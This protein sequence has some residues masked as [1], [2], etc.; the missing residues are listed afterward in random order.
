[1][2]IEF[3]DREIDVKDIMKQIKSNIAQ[4]GYQE[5][6]IDSAGHNTAELINIEEYQFILNRIWN[7][8]ADFPITTHRRGVGKL[9]VLGKKIIRKLT[10][11]YVNP[12]FEKQVDFNAHTV[13]MLNEIVKLLKSHET[14]TNKH[15]ENN[16]PELSATVEQLQNRIYE[17]SESVE[18]L[19]S[20]LRETNEFN[21]KQGQEVQSLANEFRLDA[22]QLRSDYNL[23]LDRMDSSIR[24]A[25][26]RLRRIER[27]KNYISGDDKSIIDVGSTK[28]S[29]NSQAND[30]LDFDYFLFEEYYRGSRDQIKEKQKHYLEYFGNATHVLDLGCGRGEFTEML[31]EKGVK[32]TSVDLSDDMVAYCRERGFPVIQSDVITFLETIDDNSVDGVFLSHV[33]EHMK[34]SDLI[35]LVQL[36]HRK[37]KPTGWFIAET[38]NPQTMSV[39]TQSFYMDPTHIKPV[40]PLT[41]K[42]ICE[43][44]GFH[45]NDLHYISPNDAYLQLPRLEVAGAE[46]ANLDRFNETVEHWNRIIFGCQDYFIS[47][48]K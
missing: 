33:I 8:S 4:R 15:D 31:L 21:V 7:Y 40:H 1:M 36:A 29:H 30:S 6:N 2:K 25:T 11:W 42:F 35:K 28:I 9:I 24:V 14:N 38:P 37:L 5:E 3:D 12:A 43:T 22:Q 19:Q 41:I 34:T 45:R 23:R 20:R 16:A 32:V 18:L 26:E 10:R 48:Q 39:F 44:A 47:A 46:I 17:L 13:R 27:N